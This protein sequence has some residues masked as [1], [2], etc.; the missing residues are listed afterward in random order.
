MELT[1]AD[2]HALVEEIWASY[3]MLDV[4]PAP[5]PG[6]EGQSLSALIHIHGSWEGT[7][8]LHCTRALSEQIAGAM[9]A[10]DP[11]ELTDDEIG[12][13]VGEIVNM[14]GGSVKSLVDGPASLSL[15]TVIGGAQYVVQIPGSTVLNE[16]WCTTG[17]QP[18]VVS[19]LQR[20]SAEIPATL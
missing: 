13:A 1:E 6:S 16:V 9:F 2:I 5:A 18:M 17:D 19:I 8:I 20:A 10:V 4:V 3:L 7:V 12:D 14:L 15:P 11:G